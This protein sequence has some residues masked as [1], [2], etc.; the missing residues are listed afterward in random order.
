MSKSLR[1]LSIRSMMFMFVLI[2][3][4]GVLAACGS[5]NAEEAAADVNAEAEQAEGVAEDTE[6][7]EAKADAEASEVTVT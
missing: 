5:D 1:S 4:A 6:E 2:I 7:A 3:F